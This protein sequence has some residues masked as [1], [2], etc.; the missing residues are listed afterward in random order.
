MIGRIAL[1]PYFP[2]PQGR[3]SGSEP[4]SENKF[5]L[6]FNSAIDGKLLEQR[7]GDRFYLLS[8]DDPRLEATSPTEEC[9]C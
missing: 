4:L 6:I 7:L 5:E 9:D 1:D 2:E 8:Y 3:K